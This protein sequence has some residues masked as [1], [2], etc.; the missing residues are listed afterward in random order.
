M[1]KK[2]WSSVKSYL[3][4]DECNSVL[5][6][7]DSASVRKLEFSSVVAEDNSAHTTTLSQFRPDFTDEDTT[8]IKSSEATV[9]QP[10]EGEIPDKSNTENISNNEKS[11]KE[12]QNSAYKLFQQEDAAMI[13]Q[14]AFRSY[15]VHLHSRQAFYNRLK[16]IQQRKKKPVQFS[17]T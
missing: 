5:G 2:G 7:K 3:C 14:S 4:G 1:E 9:T 13:I 10:I 17:N 16:S 15:L 12:K 6:E 8:S 11:W